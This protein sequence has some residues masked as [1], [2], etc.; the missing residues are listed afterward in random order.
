MI[1]M[2]V[3]VPYVCVCVGERERELQLLESLE[4]ISRIFEKQKC[5]MSL[6]SV[7]IYAVT[8]SYCHTNSNNCHA[9]KN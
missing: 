3:I 5:S 6:R 2:G 9:R 4:F 1:I 7:K 8:Y